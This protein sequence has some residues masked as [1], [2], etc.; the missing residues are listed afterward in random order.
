MRKL[1]FE[2]KE[3]RKYSKIREA[4]FN[5]FYYESSKVLEK[6]SI[7]ERRMEETF[8]HVFSH[9]STKGK[10]KSRNSFFLSQRE[11]P[12]HCILGEMLWFDKYSFLLVLCYGRRD[13]EMGFADD[14]PRKDRRKGL[15]AT[16]L[17]GTRI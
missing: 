15:D 7:L 17:R 14:L 1:L 11:H 4:V 5:G 12:K 13:A 6:N 8:Q 3:I 9:G 2:E 16:G 10:L